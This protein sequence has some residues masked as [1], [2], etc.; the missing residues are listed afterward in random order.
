[1]RGG[2]V[3]ER[4]NKMHERV[5]RI[6]S[7]IESSGALTYIAANCLLHLPVY[8]NE[9]IFKSKL[10]PYFM[11]VGRL[12]PRAWDTHALYPVR[13]NLVENPEIYDEIQEIVE[14][15]KYTQPSHLGT[16]WSLAGLKKEYSKEFGKFIL[17][18]EHSTFEEFKFFRPT[19]L[20]VM[21]G[22][23]DR[24]IAGNRGE[25]FSSYKEVYLSYLASSQNAMTLPEYEAIEYEKK[26]G[27][28]AT[29]RCGGAGA[30]REC[31][32]GM[33]ITNIK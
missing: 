22:M 5:E 19:D 6:L 27:P 31:N 8:T 1:M 2:H 4:G 10:A 16:H 29:C 28:M 11:G 7:G 12:H 3:L 32:P 20:T 23:S 14:G 15:M 13:L 33:F 25:I 17:L 9:V 24:L 30:C 26:F 21:V 18:P